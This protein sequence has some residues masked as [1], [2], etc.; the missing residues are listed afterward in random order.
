MRFFFLELFV[1]QR[2]QREADLKY[3]YGFTKR[4]RQRRRV[5]DTSVAGRG[6]EGD[7]SACLEYRLGWELEGGAFQVESESPDPFQDGVCHNES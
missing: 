1:D 4:V 6:L 7:T 3:I 5:M 2:S